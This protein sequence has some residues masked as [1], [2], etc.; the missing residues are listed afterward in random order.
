MTV[1]D[2]VEG[3]LYPLPAG[4]HHEVTLVFSSKWATRQ[5][6]GSLS[7]TIFLAARIAN[8]YGLKSDKSQVRW[9]IDW[10]PPATTTSTVATATTVA[11][12]TE[13]T[14]VTQPTATEGTTGGL[15][16]LW[17]WFLIGGIAVVI[18]IAAVLA[19]LFRLR[20]GNDS[21]FTRRRDHQ[22]SSDRVTYS[23]MA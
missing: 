3:N 18:M 15:W 17:V 5:P 11:T 6:S 10:T 21:L 7:W 16:Q 13:V 20:A 4:S 1:A 8:S 2:I 23:Q 14:T 12:T 19:M 9:V 22:H